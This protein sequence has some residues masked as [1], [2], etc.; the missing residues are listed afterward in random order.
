MRTPK[1]KV[2]GTT[3]HCESVILIECSEDDLP[4]FGK[5]EEIFI[6]NENILLACSTFRTEYFDFLLNSYQ[7]TEIPSANNIVKK[8]EELLF[9][10]PLSSFS[11][12]NAKYVPL[13]NH[14]RNEFYG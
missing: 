5:V 2:R 14:E 1:V 6:Y 11:I 7:V 10:Y 3:Y 8:V 13:I 12:N 4:A 9:P